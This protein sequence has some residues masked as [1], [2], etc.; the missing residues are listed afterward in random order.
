MKKILA[1]VL[2]ALMLM[3]IMPVAFAADEECKHWFNNI[4]GERPNIREDGYCYCC[5]CGVKGADFSEVIEVWGKAV[6]IYFSAYDSK[7]AFDRAD[8]VFNLIDG[9]IRDPLDESV[10]YT[11]WLYLA[12]MTSED[13]AVV[14]EIVEKSRKIIDDFKKENYIVIYDGTELGYYYVWTVTAIQNKNGSL[15]FSEEFEKNFEENPFVYEDLLRDIRNGEKEID[16]DECIKKGES[17]TFFYKCAMACTFGNHP[18]GEYTENADGSKTA[19]CTCCVATDTIEAEK[20]DI[21]DIVSTDLVE[22]IKML[23]AIVKS[24]VEAVILK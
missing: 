10:D 11:E 3:S 17:L 18:W 24:F 21:M 8:D 20:K 19:N 2:S 1:I 22:L 4:N 15:E 14:D 23:I 12:Q 9:Y 16:A 13:Q 6:G 5:K 7:I